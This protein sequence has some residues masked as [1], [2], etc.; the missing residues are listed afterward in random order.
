MMKKFLPIFY[1]GLVLLVLIFTAMTRPEPE[2]VHPVTGDVPHFGMDFPENYREDFVLYLVVDRPDLTVRHIFAAPE[3]VEALANGDPIP[4]GAQMVIE[5]FDAQTDFLG[6]PQRDNQGHYR[7]GV[8]RPNVHVMEKRPNWTIEQ[9][10]SPVGVIDWNFA[11]FDATTMLPSVENRNDCMT[12]HDSGAFRRD[13]VFSRSLLVAYV[14]AGFETQY[15]FCSR[16]GRGNC[17]R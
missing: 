14:E 1:I 5:T 2:I 10:P 7:A 11:S 12:C 6:N 15:L 9:L 4:F 3:V 17:I 13:F 16:S 8:M